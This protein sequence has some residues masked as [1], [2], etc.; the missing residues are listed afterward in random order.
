MQDSSIIG[1]KFLNDIGESGYWDAY[2]LLGERYVGLGG[3]D[4]Y[5]KAQKCFLAGQKGTNKEKCIGLC[6]EMADWVEFALIYDNA[7]KMLE[8]EHFAKGF[9]NMYMGCW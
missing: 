7:I 1:E 4:N 9:R 2:L 8:T 6:N 3:L 5:Q